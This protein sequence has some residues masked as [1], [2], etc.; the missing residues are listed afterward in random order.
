MEM[1]WFT[2]LGNGNGFAEWNTDTPPT[3]IPL[4]WGW[5]LV[6]RGS[7]SYCHPAGVVIVDS[8][9]SGWLGFGSR[10]AVGGLL[11]LCGCDEVE[12]GAV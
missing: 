9:V 2:M 12:V 8:F 5:L 11:G 3:S 1:K 7:R 10:L 4:V 6:G